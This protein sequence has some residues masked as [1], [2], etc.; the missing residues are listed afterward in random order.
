MAT[1]QGSSKPRV[2]PSEYIFNMTLMM[3]SRKV[4]AI[5]ADEHGHLRLRHREMLMIQMCMIM[6]TVMH[7]R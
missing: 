2:L 1:E 3:L 6:L 4:L 5:M 7:E